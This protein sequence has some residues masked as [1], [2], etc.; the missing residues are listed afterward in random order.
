MTMKML[1]RYPLKTL[2]KTSGDLMISVG[3]EMNI[4]LQWVNILISL[5]EIALTFTSI[6]SLK[7][8]HDS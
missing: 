2:K 6:S 4:W 1:F 3:I 7:F 5:K 8:I